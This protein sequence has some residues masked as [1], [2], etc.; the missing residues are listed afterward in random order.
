MGEVNHARCSIVMPEAYEGVVRKAHERD[1]QWSVIQA[2]T[3]FE[4]PPIIERIGEWAICKDGLHCLFT[5]YEIR[6][7]RLDEDWVEHLHGKSW[8]D[9]EEDFVNALARAKSLRDTG[10]IG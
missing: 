7:A 5:Q 1:K 9:N 10:Y 4:L 2:A 6:V 3:Y 8:L